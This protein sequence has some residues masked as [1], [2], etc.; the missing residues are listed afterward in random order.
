M[1]EN[2]KI[3]ITNF[4]QD[5]GCATL[6]QLQVLHNKSNDSFKDIDSKKE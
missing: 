5:F 1:F 6:K 2:E 4:L 3:K